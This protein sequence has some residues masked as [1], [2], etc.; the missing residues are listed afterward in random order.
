[1]KEIICD[2]RKEITIMKTMEIKPNF[3][4]LA[5]E[6][7]MDYR[8]VKRYYEGYDGKPAHHNKKSKLVEFDSIIEEKM[9]LKGAKVSALYFF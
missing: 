9:N 6:Y 1:M 7:N 5:K 4:A 8:T 3:S 2:L